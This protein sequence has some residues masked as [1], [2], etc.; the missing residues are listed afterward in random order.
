MEQFLRPGSVR[1]PDEVWVG[2]GLN[3]TLGIGTKLKSG[4]SLNKVSLV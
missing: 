4:S 1:G 3:V 2:Y